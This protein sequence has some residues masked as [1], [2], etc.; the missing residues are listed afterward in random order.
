MRIVHVHLGLFALAGCLLSSSDESN[1]SYENDVASSERGLDY[2]WSRPSS[3]QAL[4]SAGYSFVA[5]YLSYDTSG[6]NLS[7]GEARDLFAAGVDVVANWEWGANDALS[8]F[9]TGQKQAR[10]AA[11]QAAAAGMPADR[12]IYF[13]VDFDA[14]PGQQA[15][16][17]S[18]FDGVA[19]V[20]GVD[21]TGAYAGYYVIQRLFDHGKIKWGWQ[22][23]AWS[24]GQWEPRAQLRQIQNGVRVAGADCDIDQAVSADFGQWGPNAPAAS[25]S[26]EGSQAFLSP[27]QQHFMLTT[28][29]LHHS[30]WDGAAK[31]VL[32]DTWGTG[33]TGR[34][35]TFV[36]GQD[37]HT[38][39]R[40]SGGTLEHFFY[41]PSDG[42]VHHDTWGKGL[43]GDPA[44][45][46]IGAFQDVWATDTGGNLQHWWWGPQTN[47]VQHDT[48]GA[49]VVGRP[50]VLVSGAQQHVFARGTGGTLEHWWW[51]PN[52]GLSHDTWGTGLASD[53]AALAVGDFQDVWAV[54][55]S[56]AL[57]HWFWG[58]QTNGVQHD[59]WGTGAAGRPSVF[60]L[61]T[62]QHA[63]A[64]G[65]SGTLEHWF[66]DASAG[67]KHDTWGQGITADP[68]AE[69]I[70]MQQHVWAQD[71]SGTI[72]HWYWDPATNR[73][74]HDSWGQ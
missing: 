61:G 56:G 72:Q 16:I 24:G 11:A 10:D 52:G 14:S 31:R 28:G 66:W 74:V 42:T 65:P 30:Y 15:A 6:K 8:G 57:Q 13:S 34:P 37:Q 25:P 53:P 46:V 47:G 64:R 73:I 2:A 18:Y 26:A 1:A 20:L 19:S 62:Q 45:M 67:V 3:P 50:T 27:N 5:R 43:A 51:D 33:V 69:A 44:A 54:D 41:A 21:R 39:A 17:D 22:T 60:L 71:A 29:D 38:F 70:G 23:Y 68:T 9:S 59:T 7:A 40:G 48:W 32:H 36:Y 4:R 12:P 35:V 49:G 55:G 63:F 58:P